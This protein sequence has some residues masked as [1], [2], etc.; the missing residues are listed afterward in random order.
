MD[1]EEFQRLGAAVSLFTATSL[2]VVKICQE[3]LAKRGIAVALVYF[4]W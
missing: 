4:S 2:N 1:C 3:T